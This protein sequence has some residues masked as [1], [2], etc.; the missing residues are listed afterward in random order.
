MEFGNSDYFKSIDNYTDPVPA[1]EEVARDRDGNPERPEDAL[2]FTPKDIGTTTD[3]MGNALESLKAKIKHGTGRIEFGFMGQGKGNSQQ[4]TPESYGQKERRDIRELLKVNKMN[5]STHAAVHSDSL[6][7]FTQQGFNEEAR[8]RALKEIKKAV[9]FA[10]EA[11]RGGAIV[12]HVGEWYRPLEELDYE[13]DMEFEGYP[14]E[15]DNAIKFAVDS[16]TGQ[17]IGQIRKDKTIYRPQ[18]RRVKDLSPEE[19]QKYNISRN[20]DPDNYVTFD[21]DVIDEDAKTKDLFRRQPK[22]NPDET[23]FK[24]EELEWDDIKEE[25]EKRGMEPEKYYAQV[26]LENQALN[27]RGSSLFHA[28]QYE[29]TKEEYE[30]LKETYDRYKE[31]KEKLPEDEEYKAQYILPEQIQQRAGEDPEEFLESRMDMA[32]NS[33]K[34]IHEASSSADVQAKEFEQKLDRIKT[35]EEFGLDKTANT[36]ASAARYAMTKYENNK[37]KYEYDEPLYVAPEN[38]DPKNYGSHPEEYKKII[39]R[40]R[41]QFVEQLKNKRGMT[42]EEAEK[43]AKTHI[44]GTLDIG[45]LNLFREHYKEEGAGYDTFE[46]WMIDKA[47]ELVED[48]YV[49]HIHLTDNFGFDDEHLTPGE[50][51][52][53]MQDFLKKMEE[54]DM[55]DLIVEPG[56]FN[57]QTSY[58]DTLSKTKSPIYG[59]QRRMRANKTR[60]GHFGYDSPG[61]FMAGVYT[62]SN[63]FQLWSDVPLE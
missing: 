50:G 49:G 1:T 51:N 4:P 35:T 46:D 2:D 12:F 19:R 16:D 53:P 48:D 26:E 37:D 43:K 41:K 24:V 5:S 61:L 40:S 55:D 63:E 33:I 27:A 14:G 28:R 31:Y 9:D 8:G 36:I 18:Y 32:K 34:H 17:P 62:P 57:I 30:E 39:D 21:G 11:T 6:A 59:T 38:W 58:H 29:D 44:K 47:E 54:H 45:H 10:S 20:A 3:P 22:W 60:Q 42:Q 25:A 15:E 56:S 23:R 52:I 7:G 13:D